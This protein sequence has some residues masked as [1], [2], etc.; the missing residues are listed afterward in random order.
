MSRGHRE[1][2]RPVESLASTPPAA[3]ASSDRAP[4]RGEG[5]NTPRTRLESR[6]LDMPASHERP[7]ERSGEDPANRDTLLMDGLALPR[8]DVRQPVHLQERTYALRDSETRI[9][10]TVGTFRVVPAADVTSGSTTPDVWNGDIRHLSDQGLIDRKSVVINGQPTPV[11]VLTKE[12]KA[13]LEAHRNTRPDGRQQ[14][15]HAGLVKPRELAHD[16]QLHRVY[17]AEA[18][19]ITGQG[20]RVRRVVLDY[21]IKRE[22]QRFLHR[23]DRPDGVSQAEDRA[24]FAAQSRLPIVDDHLELPDLRIEYETPQGDLAYRDVELVTEHYSRAQ[25]SGKARAG[26]SMY[27]AAGGRPSGGGASG[28]GGT[29]LDPHHLEWLK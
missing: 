11:L 17:L 29:P 3:D 16:A 5:G 1:D 14:E 22:Y 24:A 2:Y 12:G 20:G 23:S 13:L 25:L 18:A 7:Q 4:V 21:E 26:F 27:R 15:Y 10:A 9:L 8:T 28:R 6:Q 19:R